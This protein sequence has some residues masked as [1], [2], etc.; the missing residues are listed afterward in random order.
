[1]ADKNHGQSLPGLRARTITI[2][3]L[4]ALLIGIAGGAASDVYALG[5]SAAPGN[6]MEAGKY[7]GLWIGEVTGN[8]AVRSGPSKSEKAM[9]NWWAG[10]RVLLYA[11]AGDLT[12]GV[13]Y[14][15]SEPPEEPM[16][17]HASMVRKVS[18]VKF[19]T[20]GWPGKWVSVNVSQQV[21]TAY[22]NGIATKVTLT[23]TGTSRTPTELGV[24]RV[25]WRTT[26][27]RMIGGSRAAGDYYDLPNVPWV[28][29][30]NETGEALHGTYWHDNFGR[31]M[32][33]GCVNLSTPMAK[34]L[35]DWGYVGMIVNV[36]N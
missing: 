36:H 5:Q 20:K 27:R 28:Q 16:Y 34:W 23:S 1:M 12:R 14:R 2:L 9:K 29:Y 6:G 35:Y 11:T 10:R 7:R 33:H 13:W 8:A 15:V 30:F 25:Q 18:Q 31:P 19:E 3:A 26:S 17:V 22:E 24:Q 32:S 21:V 4:F